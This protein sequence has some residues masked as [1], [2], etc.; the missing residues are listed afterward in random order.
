MNSKNRR[1][2]KKKKFSTSKIL[3]TL[4]FINCTA[5]E[6]F[7]AWST[8][9][10]LRMASFIG[11]MDFTPLVTLIGA[12]IGEVFGYA[13]YSLKAA[14]ENCA[15]GIL[16]DSAMMDRQENLNEFGEHVS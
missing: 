4:L 3:V 13:V 8:I 11:M 1:R 9:Q 15:G 14:K 16:Y 5:I 10:M 7:T 6:L 12:T 2:K